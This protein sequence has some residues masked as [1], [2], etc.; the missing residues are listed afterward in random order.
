MYAALPK[1]PLLGNPDLS[2]IADRVTGQTWSL[3]QRFRSKA[4]GVRGITTRV[5]YERQTHEAEIQFFYEKH[6]LFHLHARDQEITITFFTDPK[7]RAMI[8]EDETLD[9]TLREM[10][11]NKPSCS[12]AIHTAKDFKPIMEMVRARIRLFNQGTDPERMEARLQ[13]RPVAV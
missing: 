6:L 9:V 13:E 4:R 7:S 1:M 3:I 11:R 2:S 10:I 12:F 8:I 5:V